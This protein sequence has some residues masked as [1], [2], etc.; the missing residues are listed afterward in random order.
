MGHDLGGVLPL[1]N[2]DGFLSFLQI[3]PCV[4]TSPGIPSFSFFLDFASYLPECCIN[5]LNHGHP[6]TIKPDDA[7]F[8]FIYQK[9]N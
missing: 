5:I 4:L 6:V 2:H 3:F 1:Q 9:E 7:Y 8:L